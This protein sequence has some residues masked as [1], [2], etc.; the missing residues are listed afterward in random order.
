M[1]RKIEK[2]V[3]ESVE[4]KT[5][6]EKADLTPEQQEVLK[7]IN[8]ECDRITEDINNG[9]VPIIPVPERKQTLYSQ[10]EMI[11]LS[12]GRPNYLSIMAQRFREKPSRISTGIAELDEVAGGGWV[13]MGI[14]VIAAA[15]NV[16][17]T[18]ILMQSAVKM[19]QQGTAVVFITNDMR[20]ADLEAKVISQLSYS[21]A[22]EDCL[23]LSDITN[24]DKLSFDTEHNRQLAEKLEQTMKY[25]HIR[26]LIADEDFDSA[27]SKDITI[28]DKS[29]LEKIFET[30]TAVYEKVIFIVDS[31]QQV[32]GYLD[33]G[34]NGVDTMLRIFKEWSA[35]APVVLVS[36]LNRAG[37]SKEQGEIN[38]ADLKES[39]NLEYNTDLLITMVPLGFVDKT[40]NE[41][42]K[43]FKSKDYRDVM[44][45]CKK[46]RDSKE[47]DKPMTLYAPGCTFTP[48]EG[49]VNTDNAKLGKS[50]KPNNSGE[51]INLPPVDSLNWTNIN[52]A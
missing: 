17:K 2:N 31:L 15:P 37:Y 13:N 40:V 35:K 42:L 32:A 7:G 20:K 29:R 18:T 11:N 27:C 24:G 30:Y 14:S 33:S 19:A 38:M 51:N 22:G 43:A 12:M 52:I 46:S 36:T 5:V 44:I 10:E 47:V 34:K 1:D 21:L 26:D 50:S 48:F 9:R 25:L 49:K 23:R 39:G 45:T 3:V 16:G 28:A 4:T 8:A 41:D 6:Q